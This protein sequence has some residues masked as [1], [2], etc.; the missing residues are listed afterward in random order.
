M[1]Y[2]YDMSSSAKTRVITVRLSEPAARRLRAR[3][4]SLG[5]TPSAIVRDLLARE[6]GAEEAGTA[7]ERT[8]KWIGAVRDPRVVA[9][10][11]AHHAL[12]AWHP[13]RRG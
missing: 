10:R 11:D 7:A 6:L 1:S 3:A 13:D 2:T 12:D 9:G 4:R 5:V 8:E